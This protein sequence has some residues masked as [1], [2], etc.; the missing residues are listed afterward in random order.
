MEQ[1]LRFPGQYFLIESG[2]SYNWHRFYDPATGRYTQPDPLRFVD[3]PSVYGY[4]GASLMM[5]VDPWGLRSYPADFIGPLQPKDCRSPIPTHP[6]KADV[7]S[8]MAAAAKMWPNPWS[9]RNAVRNGGPWD[10]KQQGRQYENFGNFNYG[11]T[12]HSFGFSGTFLLR[13]AGRA[14]IAAGTS[15]PDWIRNT[16]GNLLPPYGDDPKD[17]NWIK[18]GLE[19]SQNGGKGG[20]SC[21]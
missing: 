3:G 12:G 7:D 9:F 4:A 15:L 20:C 10:Y 11:A 14:Q 19:Y 8:N 18:Q 6:P 13:E 2:L 5:L 17:Q 21:K 16:R 1:N